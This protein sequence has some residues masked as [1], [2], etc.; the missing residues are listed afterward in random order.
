MMQ[1]LIDK[2]ESAFANVAYPGD[3]DL[4]DSTYGEEPAALIREFRG[5]TNRK[6]LDAEFLN[7]ARDGWGTALSFFSANALR[8][9]LPAY[10]ISDIRGELDGCDPATRLCASL[11]PL[12]ARK[13]IA[14]AWGG[15]TMGDRARAEFSKFDAAQVSAIVAFLWWKLDAI[16]GR[17]PTIEQALESYWL[18]REAA[19]QE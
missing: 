17:D 13:K 19:T 15:G 6:Q 8:F 14:Q 2:I 7:Q 4:T 1:N 11:T 12:G 3:D 5:K 16:G 9:Y 18:E 10:L